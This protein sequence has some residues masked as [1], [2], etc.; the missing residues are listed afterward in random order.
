MSSRWVICEPD[1]ISVTHVCEGE[2]VI[3]GGPSGLAWIATVASA[4]LAQA[5]VLTLKADGMAAYGLEPVKRRR[6][7]H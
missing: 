1:T 5:L 3:T 7:P 6:K 4:E 2:E